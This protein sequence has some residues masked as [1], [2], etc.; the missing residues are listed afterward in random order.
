M[1]AGNTRPQRRYTKQNQYSDQRRGEKST[2]KVY[3]QYFRDEWL[4]HPDFIDWLRKDTSN[5]RKA[6]CCFCQ[7]SLNAKHSALVDHGKS[8]QHLKNSSGESRTVDTFVPMDG[9]KTS[10]DKDENKFQEI[11]LQTEEFIPTN[12]QAVEEITDNV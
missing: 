3:Q 12:V 5:L 6:I 1:L 9:N 7:K 11:I 2:T 10:S 8:L 4:D